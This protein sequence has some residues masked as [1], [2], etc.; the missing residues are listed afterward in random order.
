[1]ILLNIYVQ[2]RDALLF[3]IRLIR[4]GWWRGKGPWDGHWLD[5]LHRRRLLVHAWSIRIDAHWLEL[6]R[7]VTVELSSWGTKNNTAFLSFPPAAAEVGDDHADDAGDD[8]QHNGEHEA[9]R[10]DVSALGG[11]V[12]IVAEGVVVVVAVVE[13]ARATGSA[14]H[15]VR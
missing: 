4:R 13:V 7:I 15:T 11:Q 10:G 6:S 2:R 1:M 12:D 3:R 14:A 5:Y 8:R 9:G